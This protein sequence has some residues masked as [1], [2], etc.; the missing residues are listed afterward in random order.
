M[1]V[2]FHSFI[3]SYVI[4]TKVE[5]L[6]DK[7]LLKLSLQLP[8]KP[9]NSTM[10]LGYRVKAEAPHKVSLLMIQLNFDRCSS[11]PI[12][13]NTLGVTGNVTVAV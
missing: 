5:L 8:S 9:N 2:K 4:T 6:K 7:A 10:C 3:C 12:L 13:T 11:A 1:Q